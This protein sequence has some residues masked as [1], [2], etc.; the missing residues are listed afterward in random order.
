[1]RIL[2]AVLLISSASFA[3]S[4]SEEQAETKPNPLITSFEIKCND[5]DG[6]YKACGDQTA[7]YNR[8]KGEAEKAAKKLIVIVG[9]NYCARCR[10]LDRDMKSTLF[11]D[12]IVVH[13]A[14][15]ARGQED[16]SGERIF[17]SLIGKTGTDSSR[18]NRF[19]SIFVIEPKT[20]TGHHVNLSRFYQRSSGV[21]R[22]ALFN[23]LK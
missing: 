15:N 19:P 12:L 8:M 11:Q 21:D 2:I 10:V 14:V 23:A 22:G 16:K 13:I 1:M 20:E 17:R 3:D 4:K 7:E 6:P 9:N 18:A 5:K